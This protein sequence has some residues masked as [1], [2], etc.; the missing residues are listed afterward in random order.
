MAG[1]VG[2]ATAHRR[3][4][5]GSRKPGRLGCAS[6]GPPP[7]PSIGIQILQE[8]GHDC[9]NWNAAIF[10]DLMR[11]GDGTGAQPAARTFDFDLTRPCAA[12]AACMAL[13]SLRSAPAAACC[14][15]RAGEG[16]IAAYYG[17]RGWPMMLASSERGA[18]L[19]K[20]H[21]IKVSLGG[22]NYVCVSTAA[23]PASSPAPPHPAPTALAA[24]AAVP[25][26]RR[27]ASCGR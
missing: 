5:V 8:I 11:L 18:F 14:L 23:A 24:A 6:L 7:W 27:C 19:K 20:V 3:C 16:V 2:D 4:A 22:H 13:P 25:R 15:L 26:P 10:Y 21:A 17:I 1:G 9:T 12:R